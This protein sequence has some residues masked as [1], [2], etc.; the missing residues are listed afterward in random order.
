MNS[1]LCCLDFTETMDHSWVDIVL[2]AGGNT[3]REWFLRNLKKLEGLTVAKDG[4]TSA[5]YNIG[6]T[7]VY[8]IKKQEDQLQSFVT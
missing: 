8:N 1:L 6:S 2:M 5:S 4:V 3:K 7:T